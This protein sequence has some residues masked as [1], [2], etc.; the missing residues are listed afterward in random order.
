MHI[1]NSI[2]L[3]QIN[4]GGL[5]FSFLE[6][7]DIFDISYLDNQINLL[8]GNAFDGS[9][10]N[11]Y[12]RIKHNDS[13]RQTRLIDRRVLT[14]VI[15]LDHKIVYRG[16]FEAIN[17]QIDLVV[18]KFQWDIHVSLEATSYKEVE[19]FYGQDVAIQNR[20]SVLSSEAYTVQ[21]ID[22]KQEKGENGYTLS[23]KQNQGLAQ[24]LQI[25]SYSKNVSYSTDG[26]QFFGKTYKFSG[27]PEAL[28]NKQLDQS[29]K[30]YEFSYLALQSDIIKLD[31]KAYVSFYGYYQPE[32]DSNDQGK[33][34]DVEMMP[35]TAFNE[36][37]KQSK[38]QKYEQ[39][40]MLNGNDLTEEELDLLFDDRR[41]IEKE[42]DKILS[43][44]T[45]HHHHVVLKEKERLVERPHGHLMIHGDLL[46]VSDQVMATTNF[47]F[48]VFNSHIVLGNTSFNKFLG[49][50]RNPLNLQ[51]ISGQRIYIKK[52]DKYHML[53]VPSYYEMGG[54]TTK[55][56]YAFDD[57]AIIVDA[58]VDMDQ[59]VEQLK[60]YSKKQKS[61]DIL[62]THQLLLDVNEF[63][64]DLNYQIHGDKIIFDIS[65]NS[66]THQKYP[67]LKYQ[68]T[69]NQ[70]AKI[71]NESVL[72]GITEQHGLFVLSYKQKSYIDLKIQA[73]FDDFKD[74]NLTY[75]QA[76]DKGTSYFKS[77]LNHSNMTFQ[78]NELDIDKLNDLI[79]WY[80]HNALV[81]YASPHGLEQYNGA[82]WGTRDVC[83]GPVELF[84][85]ANRYDLIRDI[86]LKVYRRQFIENGDFP[87][88]FMFG[89]F[90]QIQAHESHGDIIVWPLRTLAYYLQATSDTQ[91]LD[92]EIAYMSMNKNE[93]TEFFTLKHHIKKQMET[94]INS[95]IPGTYLPRYGGGDW[96]DTLQPANHDLTHKMVSGWTVA[97]LYE[98][99]H[100]LG[101][102]LENSDPTLSNELLELS[103]NI[104]NDYM[105]YMIVDDIPSG[106]VV[107]EDDN[108]LT[109]LLHPRDKKTG[110]K[111][112]LLPFLRSIISELTEK[113]L[114]EEYIKLIDRVF[115]HPDGV[116]LMDTAVEY[117]GGKK[118]FFVRAET[119]A[120]FGREI[121]L[122]YVH[123]HIRY[124][125]S[126]LKTGH[127][128]RAY[129][130]I[131]QI[132]PIKM[133]DHVKNAYYRQSNMY[134]SSSDA[135]FNDRYE[136][137]K[138]FE[139][140][141]SGDI[142]VKGGWRLYSSGPGIF[143]H[144]IIHHMLGV[145][146]YHQNL[147][148]D[149]VIPLTMDGLNFTYQY[150]Q[151]ELN[152]TY[153]KGE[154]LMK[155]NG[156]VIDAIQHKN[157]YRSSGFELDKSMIN[158]LE[159]PIM[160]DIW[161]N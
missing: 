59:A 146:M 92:E 112:R 134:F 26:F 131:N 42:N 147:Y 135:N 100:T 48:G 60:V 43:F 145:G 76:D 107:F 10:M 106:F 89:K 15:F 30:Q 82:A 64:G 98:A 3:K 57:D 65:K 25:G 78:S 38:I 95:F 124:I 155:I 83:Q 31:H 19:L 67:N 51:K 5:T 2:N 46:N 28:K 73:T 119:A 159:S 93:F 160:I 36:K 12:L 13:Y 32:V 110:L 84:M 136:A 128:D 16:T 121:G 9:M 113:E 154:R 17:F 157:K 139:K 18:G 34:I 87:Q 90:Y 103:K 81:H 158:H 118:T 1:K 151:K 114:A 130:A 133:K 126:M 49:D 140:V 88:W 63:T 69:I 150:Q 104:K 66:F 11:I 56:Y 123:A 22:F 138:D 116:R 108:K 86:L 149:P 71:I 68:M 156:H 58:Y 153:H 125:E 148:L 127:A 54:A 101:V 20:A 80:T 53:A 6:T 99:F 117:K 61:Y 27:E 33:M 129:D 45:N 14:E 37:T 152:I 35:W 72:S 52:D 74:S 62:I 143:I 96:D 4:Q 70:D 142:L 8:K 50:V 75:E 141:R 29:V 109:Y 132:V 7:G 41:H 91:I 85:S 122:Q 137:K 102:E 97:L 39:A 77:I 115:M 40:P 44:F 24:Y 55:W 23:A 105:K 161:T 21:Y 144:Q 120:N 111:Y 94:I 79:F 47:M